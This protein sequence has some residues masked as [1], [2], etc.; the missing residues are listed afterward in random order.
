MENIFPDA[1][2]LTF[3]S[4]MLISALPHSE[5]AQV[6]NEDL[7]HPHQRCEVDGGPKLLDLQHPHQCCE[8]GGPK[9]LDLQHP[10]QRCEEDGGPELLDLQHPHQRCEVDGGPSCWTYNILTSVVRWTGGPS[11]WTY[12]ITLHALLLI[13]NTSAHLLLFVQMIVVLCACVC[14]KIGENMKTHR[15]VFSYLRQ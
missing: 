8:D 7:Q 5:L 9:L 12:T 14:D 4:S 6:R 3:A 13:F 11:C 15:C 2:C 1:T 10:H